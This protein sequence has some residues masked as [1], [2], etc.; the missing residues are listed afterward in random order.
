MSESN[1]WVIKPDFT[2][3]KKI[4]KKAVDGIKKIDSE[5]NA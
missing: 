1:Y 5:V 2:L 4:V 3:T